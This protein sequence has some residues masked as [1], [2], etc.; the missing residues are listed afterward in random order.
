MDTK[1]INNVSNNDINV[2]YIS[3]NSSENYIID[4]G[5][6][7]KIACINEICYI[8]DNNINEKIANSFDNFSKAINCNKVGNSFLDVDK[9]PILS[10]IPV[11]PPLRINRR[12][13]LSISSLE[14]GAS[15]KRTKRIKTCSRCK[16]H[17]HNATTCKYN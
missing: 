4:N 2:N 9:Q 8:N 12:G 16:K 7:N 10:F 6:S 5:D 3:Q 1:S 13:R 15:Y 17:G 14:N 11:L